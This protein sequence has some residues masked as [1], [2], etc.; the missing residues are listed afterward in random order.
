ML[1]GKYGLECD[2]WSM[3][4]LVYY[5]VSGSHP[6]D[7]DS[8]AD[9]HSN[10]LTLRY[11]DPQVS[12]QCADLIFKMLEYRNDIRPKFKELI[13]HEW[14]GAKTQKE[15]DQNIIERLKDFEVENGF[16]QTVQKIII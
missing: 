10:I 1:Y 4:V 12:K 6:F 11:E 3:G 2:V 7:G 15:A 13:T 16:K 8:V 5:M 9:I 14:F